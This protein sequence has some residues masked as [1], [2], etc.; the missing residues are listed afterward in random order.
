MI[1]S[2]W[3]YLVRGRIARPSSFLGGHWGEG[4]MEGLHRCDDF[5]MWRCGDCMV[6]WMNVC[7]DGWLKSGLTD[8]TTAQ[9][10][11]F[12]HITNAASLRHNQFRRL[13]VWLLG[14]MMTFQ[15]LALGLR[16]GEDGRSLR[17][18]WFVDVVI[19][20]YVDWMMAWVHGWMTG[21]KRLKRLYLISM[22]HTQSYRN[23]W[24]PPAII[25]LDASVLMQSWRMWGFANVVMCWF[26][27]CMAGWM[28]DWRKAA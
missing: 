3:L 2:D 15:L 27:D 10:R 19:W 18:R 13:G 24:L 17:M 1:C 11:I 14:W 16:A 8:Y 28:T 7:M 6:E 12:N 26:N 9:D 5:L 21:E 23:R 4:K 22:P 25:G 20:R